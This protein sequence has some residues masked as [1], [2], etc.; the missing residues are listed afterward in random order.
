MKPLAYQNVRSL[1]ET[2]ALEKNETWMISDLPGGKRAGVL[3]VDFYCQTQ[4]GWKY[5]QV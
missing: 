4:L 1:E 2:Q 5:Q 3:Q